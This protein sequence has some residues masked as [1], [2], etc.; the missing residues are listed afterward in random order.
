VS[1]TELENQKT[2]NSVDKTEA[3]ANTTAAKAQTSVESNS[4]VE[5]SSY[6]DTVEISEQG[7]SKAKTMSTSTNTD[8]AEKP[9]GIAVK[10]AGKTTTQ[11]VTSDSSVNSNNLSQYSE[12]EL[13]Q[14]L[15]KG[16]ITSA[17]YTVEMKRREE[18]KGLTDS[19]NNIDNMN[20][21]TE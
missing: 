5:T 12:Y 14:M 16:T 9:K 13:Q 8:S 11:T 4:T 18:N 19:G 3:Q 20:I 17:Q 21:A 15:S 1:K 7:L 6:G 10:S 2:I